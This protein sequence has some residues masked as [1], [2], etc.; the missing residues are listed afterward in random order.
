[1]STTVKKTEIRID[2]NTLND[3]V[4]SD[5]RLVQDIQKPNELRFFM[6]KKIPSMDGGEA[7]FSLSQDLIGKTIDCSFAVKR[8]DKENTYHDDYL[9]FSGIIFNANAR[10]KDVKSGLSFEVTAYSPDYLLYDSPHCYSYENQS[11][12]AIIS[13]TAAPYLGSDMRMK[14]NPRMD[15]DI[16]YT[17]QYNENSYEF[18]SRLASRF[19]EWFYYNGRELVFGKLEKK[20]PTQ[21]NLYY[22]IMDYQYM[23]NMEHPDFIHAHHDYISNANI[24]EDTRY[25][26]KMHILTNVAYNGSKSRYRKKTFRDMNSSFTEYNPQYDEAELSSTVEGLGRKARMM[27]CRGGS[28]RA[29]LQI[30]SVIRIHEQYKTTNGSS[31]STTHDDLQVIKVVHFLSTHGIYGN[32]FTAIPAS[33]EYP[34]YY[35]DN[36]FPKTGTQRAVVTDNQDPDQLGRVRVQFLWQQEQGNHLMTPWIRIAQPH[37]GNDK[38]FYFIPEIDEEV[39]VG[40][41]N[42]NAEKPYVIG[43]LYHGQQRPG[44]NWYSDSNDIKAIRTRNGHTIEVNDAGQGGFIRIYDNKKENYVLTLS[45]DEKL[46]KIESTGNIEFRAGKSIIMDAKEDVSITAGKDISSEAKENIIDSAGNNMSAEAGNDISTTAGNDILIDAGN[47][48]NTKVGNDNALNIEKS[49][50]IKIGTTKKEDISEEYQLKANGIKIESSDNILITSKTHE[51]KADSM[52]LEG[53][54]KLDF[55]ASSMKFNQ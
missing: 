36:I 33:C 46:V 47:D 52:K 4:F 35:G 21:M 8:G 31:V 28:I 6:H 43:T 39:M 27:I 32:E 51:Q 1:M 17:V 13:E 44:S 50:N 9:S 10:R 25:A 49:Q 30:G 34:P 18:I 38:G 48:M 15:K 7:R 22:D 23:L 45:T 11:L 5:I 41:E 29:D 53:G 2:G 3:Y 20:E 12:K 54:N 24:Q 37:G 26:G 16:P 14:I 55:K 40:F 19:G 42:G